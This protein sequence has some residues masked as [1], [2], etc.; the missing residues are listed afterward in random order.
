[1]IHSNE[2]IF[3][4]VFTAPGGQFPGGVFHSKTAAEVWIK[5]Y[6]LTGT[7][8]KYPVN[9]GAFDF[10][11]E[12]GWYKPKEGKYSSDFIAKFSCASMEHYHF[13]DGDYS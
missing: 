5:K 6:N 2:I 7:L 9:I 1:M 4:W 10:A 12:K 13:E 3:V 8:T 11:V